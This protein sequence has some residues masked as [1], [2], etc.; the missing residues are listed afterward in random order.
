MM[1]FSAPTQHVGGQVCE[2]DLKIQI[3]GQGDFP[4][5]SGSKLKKPPN[6]MAL[7]NPPFDTL[8]ELTEVTAKNNKFRG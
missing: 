7:K 2:T 4:K 8:C 1:G 6:A 3:Q 5:R